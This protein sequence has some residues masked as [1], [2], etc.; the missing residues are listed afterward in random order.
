MVKNKQTH[1][2]DLK[3]NM[4]FLKIILEG[5]LSMTQTKKP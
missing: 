4:R 5:G 1:K 3:E 2:Q